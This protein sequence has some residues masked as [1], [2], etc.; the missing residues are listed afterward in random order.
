MGSRFE[1]W[2]RSWL[3]RKTAWECCTS[4]EASLHDSSRSGE[5]ASSET[6]PPCTS[7]PGSASSGEPCNARPASVGIQNTENPYLPQMATN[8]PVVCSK[9]VQYG[10][11][12][13]DSPDPSPMATYEPL[14]CSKGGQSAILKPSPLATNDPDVCSK[15]VQFGIQ[16][17]ESPQPSPLATS[18]PVICSKGV[19]L[20]LHSTASPGR[21]PLAASGPVMCSKGVQFGSFHEKLA[22]YLQIP[23]YSLNQPKPNQTRSLQRET[24]RYV[25]GQ[26]G[27]ADV[28]LQQDTCTH[29]GSKIDTGNNHGPE[30][31]PCPFTIVEVPSFSGC[32]R[33]R[34]PCSWM[35]SAV[36]SHTLQE[37][38][39]EK[40]DEKEEEEGSVEE[41]EEKKKMKKKKRKEREKKHKKAIRS[42]IRHTL[43][44]LHLLSIGG[45]TAPDKPTKQGGWAS[46]LIALN[47]AEPP[48]DVARWA[49]QSEALAVAQSPV[50]S[51]SI[52]RDGG[53]P[54]D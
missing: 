35:A 23:N 49:I 54:M 22:A 41:E 4:P 37:E 5:A 36:P 42:H 32:H 14:I 10:I 21:L 18:E 28:M 3:R 47:D 7:Q 51:A 12:N 25:L 43:R 30:D 26:P 44:Q 1:S 38:E 8:E 33:D 46:R 6:K 17:A 34:L 9:G 48:L 27:K 45:P 53:G 40:E 39:D 16:D 52:V 19:Q 29:I 50:E 2:T 15:G 31:V 24:I 13:R 11:Q 20:G